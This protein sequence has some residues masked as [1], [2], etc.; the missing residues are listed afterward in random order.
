MEDMVV[1]ELNATFCA[2]P[3]CPLHLR[4]GDQGVEGAGNWARLPCGAIVSRQSV[5]GRMLCDLCASRARG[6][7]SG[8]HG[9][10]MAQNANVSDAKE[11]VSR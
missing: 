9:A 11:R 4:P 8:S 3:V 10:E 5:D 7:T 2:N 6:V 1:I